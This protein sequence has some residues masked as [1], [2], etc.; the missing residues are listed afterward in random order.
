[1]ALR[2]ILPDVA[3]G[4]GDALIPLAPIPIVAQRNPTASDQA[5][6]GTVWVNKVNNTVYVLTSV[7]NNVASWVLLEAGGGAGVFSSLTVNPGPTNLSTVGNGA[8]NIG[9]ASNTG[10]VTIN[11]GGGGFSLVGAAGLLSIAPGAGGLEINGA[12]GS[13]TIDAGASGFT[14]DGNGNLVLIG[15]D[16]AANTVHVGST[17]AGAATL[18]QGGLAMRLA[19]NIIYPSSTQATTPYAV[20]SGD[21][22]LSINAAAGAFTVTLPAAPSTGKTYVIFDAFGHA[23]ANNITINGNGNNIT[24]GGASAAT[25]VLN[26]NYQSINLWFDGVKWLGQLIA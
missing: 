18:I 21:Y 9:N 16:N 2:R 3:Y 4:L 22:Q 26:T 5:Q 1:M 10:I 19:G 17:N 12:G 6:L 11:G 8:V 25:A 14:L 23:A 20:Q 13:I 24:S 15:T 7:V